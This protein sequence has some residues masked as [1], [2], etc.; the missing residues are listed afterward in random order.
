M[1]GASLIVDH[2]ATALQIS[3]TRLSMQTGVSG[4][5]Q[6]RRLD[7]RATSV[8]RRRHPAVH[9]ASLR[10]LTL[11]LLQAGV[12]HVD[13]CTRPSVNKQVYTRQMFATEKPTR[14]AACDRES[15]PSFALLYLIAN[16]YSVTSY[17]FMFATCPLRTE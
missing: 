13:Y 1:A 15:P 14:Q 17:H 12:S 10:L 7:P 6:R 3:C 4:A 8:R 2:F 16:E 5:D 9:A 11:L